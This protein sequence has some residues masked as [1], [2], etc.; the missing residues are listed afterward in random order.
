MVPRY[1][2]SKIFVILTKE[3]RVS[4]LANYLRGCQYG[5]KI[6]GHQKGSWCKHVSD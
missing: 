1:K 4:D 2:R 3:A 6:T 5:V